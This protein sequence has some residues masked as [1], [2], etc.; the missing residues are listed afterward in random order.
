[1][2]KLQVLGRLDLFDAN[3]RVLHS[4]LAQPKRQAV[5]AYLAVAVPRGYHRRESLLALLWPDSDDEHARGSLSKAISHLRQ[6]LGSELLI[7]RGHA[8]LGLDWHRIWCDAI[9]FEDAL[10]RGAPAEAMALYGGDLLPGFHIDEAPEFDQWLERERTRLRGRAVQAARELSEREQSQGR[11]APS[12]EW[13]RRAAALEPYDESIVRRLMTLLDAANDRA[14]ALRTYDEFAARLHN[15]LETEPAPETAAVMEA[16]RDRSVTHSPARSELAISDDS[17]RSPL[18]SSPARAQPP[19]SASPSNISRSRN[20]WPASTLGAVGIIA[21]AAWTFRGRRPD[22]GPDAPAAT[23]AVVPFVVQGA[24]AV[25]NLGEGMVSLLAERFSQGGQLHALDAKTIRREAHPIAPTTLGADSARALLGRFR[26]RFLLLGEATAVGDSL[27]VR[28]VL[29]DSVV[30]REAISRAEVSGSG[31]DLARLTGD[32]AWQVLATSPMYAHPRAR[33]RPA[34]LTSSLP[35]LRS[36]LVG[37]Q[38]LTAGH[39]AEA[40]KAYKAAVDSD[41]S[42][43]IAYLNLGRAAN[44]AG[45]YPMADFASARA[46]NFI[47]RLTP[48]DQ[49]KVRARSAYE[50]GYPEESER[51]L[52]VALIN[53]VGDASAWFDLGEIYFHWGGILGHPMSEARSAYEQALAIYG[54]DVGSLVHLARIAA[55]DGRIATVDSLTRKALRGHVDEPQALELRA[56]R[57]YAMGDRAEAD[58]VQTAASRLDDNAAYSVASMLSVFGAEFSSSSGAAAALMGENHSLRS[59]TT[60]VILSAQLAMAHGHTSRAMSIL[61]SGPAF[62][63]A[64]SIEYR[65]ALAA[66]PFR[67]TSKAEALAL[68][69]ELVDLRDGPLIGP[70]PEQYAVSSIY[71]ARRSYLFAMLSLKGADTAA[72]LAEAE[73]L[74]RPVDNNNDRDYRS[75]TA[76]L[77]RAEVDRA[78]GKPAQALADLGAPSVLPARVLPGPLH[79]PSAHERFLR[80]ELA[81]T[82]GHNEEALRWYGTFPDPG[83]YDLMYLPAVH[84][85]A[86]TAF[87]QQNDTAKARLNYERAI[88]LLSES[89]PEWVPYVSVLRSRLAAL[90]R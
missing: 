83:A 61:S 84:A 49:L 35:A 50:H 6:S 2:I 38:E 65:A 58:R 82:L 47:D 14:G 51:L 28:A 1:M 30:G 64:R 10:D 75:A 71:P 24:P 57:A 32:L 29:Y 68:R 78:R 31:S 54:N 66:L 19:V 4:V 90:P 59:R 74:D 15:E 26:P 27:R 53:E 8:E 22:P 46:L 62:G 11:I 12:I 36:F 87:A 77:I 5:L 44:W 7:S 89:D 88:A 81:R 63:A 3:G 13:A 52:N 72:A 80:A 34:D 76:R 21:L 69:K 85:G 42:L 55:A 17:N 41:S 39:F 86:G 25:A 73:R 56:L 33:P 70:G 40:V 9:G 20:W 48:V 60:G 67:P 43:A 16:I 18:E 45:D 37:E 23:I 79:Y